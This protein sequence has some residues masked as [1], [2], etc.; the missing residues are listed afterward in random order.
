MTANR[1][2]IELAAEGLLTRVPGVGTFVSQTQTTGHLLQVRN[3]AEEVRERGHSYSMDVLVHDRVK[4]PKEVAVW[5]G[6]NSR[7]KVFRTVVVHNEDDVP[8]QLEKRFVNPVSTPVYAKIDLEE[9]TPSEYL[10]A[11]VPLQR[12]EHTVLA[13]MPNAEIM[14]TLKMKKNVPC[15]VLDRKTW[16][17]GAPISFVHLYHPGD[18][19]ALTDSFVPRKH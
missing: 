9:S 17:Q 4:P 7:S 12:V 16:S 3:I 1:A 2:L 14:R 19:Y 18:N 6:L 15:L 11:N 10:L 8:I 5:M 13:V